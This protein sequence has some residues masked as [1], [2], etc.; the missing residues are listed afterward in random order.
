MNIKTVDASTLEEDYLLELIIPKINLKEK[1]Y[2]IDSSKNNVDLHIQI[3][4]ESTMPDGKNSSIFL[5]AHRGNTRVS[6]FENLH[7]LEKGDSVYIDYKKVR[8]IYTINDFFLTEKNGTIPLTLENKDS[9]TLITCDKND[10]TK[11]LV[12]I[13]YKD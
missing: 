11:Q 8:Y 2:K 13:G 12:F 1:V 6:Y 9:I 3:L 5:A 10:K 4:K 7:K